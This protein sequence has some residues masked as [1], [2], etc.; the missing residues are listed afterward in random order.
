MIT[1]T[2]PRHLFTIDVEDYFHSEDPDLAG[3]DRHPLRVEA[4][5]RAVLECCAARG[6]RGTFFVLGWVAE[7]LPQLVREI[8]AAGHEIASHGSDHR[9]VYRQSRT[10]FL[11]DVRRARDLLSSI[12]GLPVHGYR[13]PYFSIVAST[14]WAHDALLEAGYSYSSSVFPGANP[15]YGIPGANTEPGLLATAGGSAIIEIPITTF[16]SRVGCGGVYFRA[17]PYDLFRLGIAARERA[18]RRAVF[19]LHPWE[20]DPGKPSP[21]GSAWLRLRHDVGIRG[22]RA[23]LERLLRD[24]EFQ[25]VATFLAS[26]PNLARAP[27]VADLPM[28]SRREFGAATALAEEARR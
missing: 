10:E 4:S 2:R 12:T 8:A 26:E 6:A 13:A 28:I 1:A 16:F 14:P 11:D 7:R 24:F 27:G 15:R 22:A 20:I 25:S 21:D 3:W 18:G 23:R 19:Y 5:T 17:L 9:F